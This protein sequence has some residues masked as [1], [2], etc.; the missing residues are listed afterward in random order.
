[1]EPLI[2]DIITVGIILISALICYRRGFAASVVRL[3]G[4]AAAFFAASVLSRPMAGWA[5][6][7]F[8]A[9]R[10]LAAVEGQM[11]GFDSADELMG[12]IDALIAELPAGLGAILQIDGRS[13]GD[14]TLTLVEQ[15]P[16]S[17]LSGTIADRA[18]APIVTAM[19]GTL[20][21][22]MMFTLF[23]GLVRFF[24]SAL[25]GLNRL[26]LLGGANALFGGVV[27]IL[28]GALFV[29][30]LAM[31]LRLG[32]LATQ[33]SLPFITDSQIQSSRVFVYFYSAGDRLPFSINFG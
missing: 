23:S 14:W 30:L 6:E 26:P 21:F 1:M 17:E 31:A 32:V 20:V 7:R 13:I 18:V 9:G 10:I 3:V 8:F 5:Y 28:E 22:F 29:L 27:G 2:L 24:V 16:F 15:V 19:L 25:R 11:R 33:N 12:N 4:W